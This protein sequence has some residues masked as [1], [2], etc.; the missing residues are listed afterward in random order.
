MKPLNSTLRSRE[1]TQPDT[2]IKT[3]TGYRNLCGAN[4]IIY[5]V[6]VSLSLN[7]VTFR[8]LSA[9]TLNI[10]CILTIKPVP[11]FQKNFFKVNNIKLEA[12]VLLKV[13][14]VQIILR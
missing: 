12:Y 2:G 3:G 11:V 6:T 10:W 1:N 13:T 4:R 5:W 9:V 8:S 14:Y 7:E